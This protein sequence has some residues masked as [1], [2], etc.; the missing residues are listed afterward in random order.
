[1]LYIRSL[2]DQP[3]RMSNLPE[4]ARCGALLTRARPITEAQARVF[5]GDA[6]C[7]SC[8]PYGGRS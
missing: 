7:P 1:M 6:R 5:L 4:F 2:R 3:H 8:F